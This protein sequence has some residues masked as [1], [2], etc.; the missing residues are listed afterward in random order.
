MTIKDIHIVFPHQ[1]FKTTAVL[2]Q[3]DTIYLVEEY[4]FFNQYKFHKQKIAFHRAS[5]KAY[6]D[7]LK[8]KHKTVKYIEATDEKSDVRKLLPYLKEKGTRLVHIIDPTDNW[9][10]K[11]INNA[12]N[13]LKI[14]WH[15][16]PLFINSKC[17]L[18]VFKNQAKYERERRKNSLIRELKKN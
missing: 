17:D 1:L 4:L 11:H 15:N 3:V 12:S 6:A 5:M 9:L 16:T 18:S 13:G 2:E 10:E 8:S 14:I 7:H